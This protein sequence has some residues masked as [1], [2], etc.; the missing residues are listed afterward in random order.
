MARSPKTDSPITPPLSCL[1]GDIGA[2]YTRFAPATPGGIGKL[3]V[4]HTKEFDNIQSAIRRY[5]SETKHRFQEA[6]FAAAGP[7]SNGKVSLVNAN[8][9]F[10]KTELQETFNFRD[11][12]LLNDFEAVAMAMPSIVSKFETNNPEQDQHQPGRDLRKIGGGTRIPTAPMAVIGPGTGLGVAGL[13]PASDHHWIA[14]AGEGGHATMASVTSEESEVIS[15]LQYRWGHVSAERALS[16]PGLADLYYCLCILR[17]IKARPIKDSRQVTQAAFEEDP[18]DPVCMGAFN[19]FCSMLGTVAGNVA[20][21]FG[22]KGG[23]FI[24]GGILPR[25][26]DRLMASPFR[27]RFESKG[28]LSAYVS[29]IPTYLVL[30]R[31]P[32]LQG[33]VDLLTKAGRA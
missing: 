16:G 18:T 6:A 32:A 8:W 23:L 4:Y 25:Y 1:V 31:A 33:L 3:K 12:I 10:S 22:A 21:T 29:N 30:H 11:V 24:S 13:V 5:I 9:C 19:L 20:L 7:V 2:T 27:A 15:L 28:R 17:G 26:S 14:L